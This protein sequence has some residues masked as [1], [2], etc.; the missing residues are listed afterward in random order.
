MIRFFVMSVLVLVVSVSAASAGVLQVE[1]NGMDTSTCGS[2]R[3]PCRSISRA[4]ER[5]S[6]GDVILV[7]PGRYGDANADGDFND[8]G[9]EIAEVGFGCYCAVKVWKAVTIISNL[10]AAMTVIDA[11]LVSLEQIVQITASGATFGQSGRGFSVNPSPVGVAGIP[12]GIEVVAPSDVTVAGNHVNGARSRGIRAEGTRHQILHN[13]VKGSAVGLSV[14]GTNSVITGNS[15]EGNSSVGGELGG[16]GHVIEGNAFTGNLG[17]GLQIGSDASLVRG[18]AII[19]NHAEGIRIL[20]IGESITE[21]NIYGNACGV[22]NA[23]NSTANA[24]NNF[25]GSALGPGPD[26]A[27]QI[28]DV[29]GSSTFFDAPAPRPFPIRVR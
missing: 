12:T 29:A 3:S 6:P 25:W 27:D 8:S 4:I 28:C 23:S 5:A 21:N 15:S 24:H 18:N 2:R 16:S 7:G 26:P 14:T 19:G 20:G 9:D 13:V 1:T 22:Q 10:G 11:P 17:I